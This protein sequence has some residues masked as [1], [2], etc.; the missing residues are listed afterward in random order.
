M[1]TCSGGLYL[2]LTGVCLCTP[3]T[4]TMQ[5]MKNSGYQASSTNL[6]LV[7]ANQCT[8][9]DKIIPDTGAPLLLLSCRFA[10]WTHPPACN[11]TITREAPC[12]AHRR[13]TERPLGRPRL[14]PSGVPAVDL[15]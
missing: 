6:R 13:Q 1:S 5:S 8:G 4:P 9:V 15:I 11:C 7:H 3:T 12:L 2:C 14:P 10:T